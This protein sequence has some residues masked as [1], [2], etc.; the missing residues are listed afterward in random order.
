MASKKLHSGTGIGMESLEE[1]VDHI[2]GQN[3]AA[4]LAQFDSSRLFT[5]LFWSQH[6]ANAAAASAGSTAAPAAAQLKVGAVLA[7]PS[8]PTA[9]G[10]G[11]GGGSHYLVKDAL[12]I[13]F[14]TQVGRRPTVRAK[15]LLPDFGLTGSVLLVDGDGALL[16]SVEHFAALPDEPDQVPAETAAS[17]LLEQ[18]AGAT[19]AGRGPA[20]TLSVDSRG[21]FVEVAASGQSCASPRRLYMFDTVRVMVGV[22]ANRSSL[23]QLHFVFLGL[24]AEADRSPATS[25]QVR[26]EPAAAVNPAAVSSSSSEA[27]DAF[28]KEAMAG[29]SSSAARTAVAAA[30]AAAAAPCALVLDKSWMAMYGQT[31]HGNSIAAICWGSSE[32]SLDTRAVGALD[33]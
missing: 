3:R 19:G 26:R 31:T 33:G 27:M 23:P 2:N 13:G 24:A 11:G 30:D 28:R 7:K 4:K 16:Q 12:V 14:A 10:G 29:Q 20:S 32:G 5:A 22:K 8:V 18:A 9:G 17:F 15:V 25:R 21:Q 1:V 6:V